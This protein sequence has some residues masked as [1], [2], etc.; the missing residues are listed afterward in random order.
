MSIK[1]SNSNNNEPHHPQDDRYTYPTITICATGG[2][3]VGYGCDSLYY[4]YSCSST[5]ESYIAD[6]GGFKNINGE[7][8]LQND[9]NANEVRAT[10]TILEN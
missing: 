8:Y 1:N 10:L 2:T 9:V 7:G 5:I 4:E 6:L 3:E